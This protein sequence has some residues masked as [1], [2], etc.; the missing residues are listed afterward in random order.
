VGGTGF[1]K[2]F[3]TDEQ[4]YALKKFSASETRFV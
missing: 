3:D 2:S 4:H 1:R